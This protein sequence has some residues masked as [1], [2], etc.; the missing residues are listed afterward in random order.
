MLSQAQLLTLNY[1]GPVCT[2]LDVIDHV[3]ILYLHS[4]HGKDYNFPL[5]SHVFV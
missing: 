1:E 3:D 2:D 5:H 4:G